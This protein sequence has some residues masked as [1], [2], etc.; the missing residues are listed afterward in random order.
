VKNGGGSKSLGPG[1]LKPLPSAARSALLT[2]SFLDG[3]AG[4]Q[5]GAHVD[6]P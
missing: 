3:A 1:A 4:Q 6:L 2:G 5:R